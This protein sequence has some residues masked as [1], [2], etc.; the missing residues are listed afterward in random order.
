MQ[1][2]P[3]TKSSWTAWEA[4]RL[5]HDC[6]DAARCA[7]ADDSYYHEQCC[8]EGRWF[9][10]LL[11]LV[12]IPDVEEAIEPK[13]SIIPTLLPKRSADPSPPIPLNAWLALS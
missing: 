1:G 10:G 2:T 3:L 5:L 7:G 6:H 11:I 13:T 12:D 9:K 8:L 4:V